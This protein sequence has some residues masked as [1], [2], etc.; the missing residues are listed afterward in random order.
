VTLYFA[1]SATLPFSGATPQEVIAALM[2]GSLRPLRT[3]RPDLDPALVA[4]V[5]RATAYVPE[6]RF[7]TAS[8]FHAAL[9][10][11]LRGA[12]RSSTPLGSSAPPQASPSAHPGPTTTNL[13]AH[14][15]PT[16]VEPAILRRRRRATRL[17]V[18]LACAGLLLAAALVVVVVLGRSSG[19]ADPSVPAVLA[20]DPVPVAPIASI[21]ELVPVPSA[22]SAPPPQAPSSLPP[23]ATVRGQTRT[24]PAAPSCVRPAWRCAGRCVDLESDRAHCGACDAACAAD[25]ACVNGACTACP[26][27]VGFSLCDG[28]CIP[29]FTDPNN[30]GTCQRKCPYGRCQAGRCT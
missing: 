29:T 30:C 9:A 16:A 11:W 5:D 12:T 15:L 6:Q 18:V 26:I 22:T 1:L 20:T 4:I 28:R 25:K 3:V 2:A 10:K 23:E 21:T 7:P 27:G 24:A 8:E 17:G 19:G 14:A 13:V